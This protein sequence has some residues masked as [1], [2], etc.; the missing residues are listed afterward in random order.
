MEDDRKEANMEEMQAK[1]GRASK[2][3]QN[4]LLVGYKIITERIR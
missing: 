4:S 3:I 2:E 1:F